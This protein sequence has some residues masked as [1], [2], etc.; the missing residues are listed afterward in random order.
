M[1]ENKR[2]SETGTV[3]DDESQGS[4]ATRLT[5]DVAGYL[6]ICKFTV[7]FVGEI[8]LKIDQHLVQLGAVIF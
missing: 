8:R 7:E 1:S 6:L 3:V 2:Q 4:V 5:E